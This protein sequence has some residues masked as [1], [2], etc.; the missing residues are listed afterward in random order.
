MENYEIR[1]E[2]I[3]G[4]GANLIGKLLGDIGEY[5]ITKFCILW[6]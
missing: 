4:F 3:G 2:S 1:I 5:G 6:F